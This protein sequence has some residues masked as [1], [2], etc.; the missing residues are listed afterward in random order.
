M[1]RIVPL[2]L[3]TACASSPAGRAAAPPA[4][5]PAPA[6]AVRWPTATFD[7]RTEL[8]AAT[9][10]LLGDRLSATAL[11]LTEL[12]THPG[13]ALL[14]L[15]AVQGLPAVR[16]LRKVPRLGGKLVAALDAAVA[17]DAPDRFAALTRDL[18]A[19]TRVIEVG[20]TL[21]VDAA[22]D[23][24]AAAVHTLRALAFTIADRRIEVP[25]PAAA[26]DAVR[27]TT[28]A[29]AT[30]GAALTLGAHAFVVPYGEMLLTAAGP[31]VFTRWGGATLPAALAAQVDCP[32][33]A[34]RLA[35]TCELKA[36]LRDAVPEAALATLCD[37]AV[38]AVAAQVEGQITAQ[39]LDVLA[40]EAGR[41]ERPAADPA[42]TLHGSW[43]VR[44]EADGQVA[45]GTA[46]FTAAPAAAR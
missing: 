11:L 14:S 15:A 3:L 29:V 5:T 2:A 22:D 4:T 23:G 24:E 27:P 16:T 10:G 46:P 19:L 44:V 9:A 6:P 34:A 35:A 40:L 12:D 45:T 31:L 38:A 30:D 26:V 33:V 42:A 18:L 28:P 32:R 36:C 8:D 37:Q 25:V 7:V 13:R 17:G 43:T 39:R 21:A 41:I 1:L 20:T